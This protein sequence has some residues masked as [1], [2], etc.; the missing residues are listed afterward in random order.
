MPYQDPDLVAV[1]NPGDP[2]PAAWTRVV[3]DDLEDIIDP[4]ACSVFDSGNQSLTSG[5]FAAM[6]ADSENFDN[7]GMH[8]PVTNN[9]RLTIQTAGRYQC[10]AIVSFDA[11]STGVRRLRFAVNGVAIVDSGLSLPPVGALSTTL[12]A[13]KIIALAVGDFVEIQARQDSGGALNAQLREFAAF[14]VTR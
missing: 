7:D 11:S 1:I 9:T 13:M 8:D 10:Q 3:R 6:N 12:N 14:R 2:I 4:P 5:N